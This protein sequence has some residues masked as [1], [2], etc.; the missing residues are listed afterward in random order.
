MPRYAAV[1]I[2][3]N[4][5]RLLVSETG[6]GGEL[7]T[8]ALDRQVTRLGESVF[9]NG[10][11]SAEAM[12]FLCRQLQAHA[13]IYRTHDVRAIRAVATAAIRDASNRQ[14]FLQR[15]SQALG[16][17]VE[18]ISGQEEA[19]LIHLG[20]QT[21]WPHP[22]GRLLVVDVG[23]GSGEVMLSHNGR[24][25]QAYSKPLGAVRLTEVFLKSDPPTAQELHR[26]ERFIDEKLS[27]PLARIGRGRFDRLVA[28]SATA[29]AVVCAVNRVPRDRREEADRYR[30]SRAQVRRL[31][32]KV[33]E[34]PL[35]KR[36]RLTGI[37]PRR[38]EIVVAGAAVFHR[39]LELFEHHSMY[40]LNSGVRDG[41]VADLAAR[42]V[43]REVARL[44][45]DQRVVVEAM[46]R[47][48][49][50][51]TKHSRKVAELTNEIFDSTHHLHQLPAG[52][53]R[54]L[55]AAAYLLDIGH[56]VSDTGHHK[57]SE[58]LV[59]NAELPGFTDLERRMIGLLCRFHRKNMP[60]PRHAFF[61]E[62]D[63]ESKRTLLLMI[64]LIRLADGL[65]QGH[66]QPV[67]S[68]RV[69]QRNGSLQVQVR[70][71]GDID[72]EVWSAESLGEV[73]KQAYGLP[74]QVV[75]LR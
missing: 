42:G 26:M 51:A 20:V 31:Y 67:E 36:R 46:A 33:R 53:G 38:A 21:R 28:T 10:I 59:A 56:F 27:A 37:G 47:K 7:R 35:E 29:A 71:K 75:K 32:E 34:M 65:D 16:A 30:A 73:F 63:A 74:L 9:R 72:L 57:H 19:R 8:L 62:L 23:G 43:G 6:P 12:E 11:V 66:E 15:A 69:E 50:V 24:L 22:K 40:Y 49:G 4:S 60:G 45:R 3:S 48:F 5:V 55:E 44:T 52:H 68:V 61:Q 39:V 18:V 70:A 17:E 13:A 54:L 58:Y 14:E 64:P 41:I 25:E 1:D 2:G